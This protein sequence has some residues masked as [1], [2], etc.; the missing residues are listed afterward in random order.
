MTIEDSAANRRL[1]DLLK[2]VEELR[3]ILVK[4]ASGVRDGN[5]YW[6]GSDAYDY[7]LT[8]M[9]PKII[10][11]AGLCRQP[12]FAERAAEPDI[13]ADCDLPF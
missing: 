7:A 10:Q 11:L 5:G 13:A 8:E 4:E 3:D 9:V 6:H 1:V 2:A 12:G